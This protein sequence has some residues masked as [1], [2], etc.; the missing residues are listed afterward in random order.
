MVSI[1]DSSEDRYVT[2]ACDKLKV[3]FIVKGLRMVKTCVKE[4]LLLGYQ[5]SLRSCGQ[6]G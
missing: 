2:I 4:R 1:K 5:L 3:V 6:K